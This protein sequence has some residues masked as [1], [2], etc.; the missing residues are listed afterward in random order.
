[1]LL[2]GTCFLDGNMRESY[3]KKAETDKLTGSGGDYE[4]VTSTH[5]LF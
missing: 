1:M 3:T 4:I 2:K 5:A